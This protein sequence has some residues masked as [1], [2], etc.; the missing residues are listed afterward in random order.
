VHKKEVYI[1][2]YVQE[3]LGGIGRVVPNGK[4]AYSFRVNF[5]KDVINKIVPHFD[6]YPLK[7]QKL[8]DYLLCFYPFGKKP[9][10]YGAREKK[11]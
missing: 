8:A 4:D 1:L 3:Q 10:P 7:S 6:N 11:Y 9:C 2:T 5:I